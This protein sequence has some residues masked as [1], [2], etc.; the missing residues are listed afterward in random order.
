MFF[1]IT[2]MGGGEKKQSAVYKILNFENRQLY[3]LKNNTPSSFKKKI[4][5][6]NP[7]DSIN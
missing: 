6:I 7:I 3:Y 5:R 2:C 1:G 4:I